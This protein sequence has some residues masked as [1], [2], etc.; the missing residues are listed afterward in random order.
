MIVYKIAGLFTN[1]DIVL[2]D[3]R[4]KRVLVTLVIDLRDPEVKT[5][6]KRK[7][8]LDKRTAKYRC[9]KCTVKSIVDP[10][11]QKEYTVAYSIFH[12]SAV[13]YKV[14]ETLT[15]EDYDDA[16][17]EVCAPGIHFF[18]DKDAALSASYQS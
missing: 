3:Q 6:L 11:T 5:N 9:N 1:K 2:N 13:Q 14:N 12:S 8:I 15:V 10:E 4:Q 17:N 18:I 16:E 7:N